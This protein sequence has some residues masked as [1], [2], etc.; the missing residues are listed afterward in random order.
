MHSCHVL[1]IFFCIDLC[2]GSSPKRKNT[3]AVS[4]SVMYN[5]SHKTGATTVPHQMTDT[6]EIY[7]MSTKAVDKDA[8]NE[9]SLLYAYAM[10]DT[11]RVRQL[12]FV[13]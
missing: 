2:S 4:N 9:P 1:T 6:G 5:E 8:H 3:L 12:L 10:V 13:H 7:A 11:Q